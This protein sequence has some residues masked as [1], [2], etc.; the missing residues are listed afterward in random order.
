TNDV[1]K[2]TYTTGGVTLDMWTDSAAYVMAAD[3]VVVTSPTADQTITFDPPPDRTYGS[4]PFGLNAQASSGLPVSL[5][6]I[7]GPVS[8]VGTNV[9]VTGIGTVTVRASQSGD[10]SFKASPVV[11]ST[12]VI[13]SAL[14]TVQ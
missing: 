10:A 1:E 5:R 3:D 13:N 4:G 9:V 12:F 8:L 2:Q 14:I 7:S 6:L 11:D